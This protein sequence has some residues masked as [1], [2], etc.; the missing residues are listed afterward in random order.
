M[1]WKALN[2]RR[3]NGL[4]Q[5]GKLCK[6]DGL[7]SESVIYRDGVHKSLAVM[8][9]VSTACLESESLEF[10]AGWVQDVGALSMEP[11]WV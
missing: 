2:G 1:L 5:P 11:T 7:P 9:K 8:V 4:L 3:S 10:H 6:Q